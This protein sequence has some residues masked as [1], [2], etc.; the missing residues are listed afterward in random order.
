MPFNPVCTDLQVFV[1]D[2]PESASAQGFD[3]LNKYRDT[4]PLRIEQAVVVH[5]GMESGAPTVDLVLTDAQG[6]KYVTVVT[7]NILKSLPLK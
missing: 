1:F 7:G 2:N 4:K 6:N 3:R 5:K